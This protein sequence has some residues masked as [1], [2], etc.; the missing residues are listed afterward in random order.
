MLDEVTER[1]GE[2]GYLI[3]PLDPPLGRGISL[4][5]MVSDVDRLCQVIMVEGG[6][7]TRDIHDAWYRAGSC[8]IGQ[9]QFIVA[10]PDGYLLRFS[11]PLGTRTILL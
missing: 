11:Q 9:R 4:Q 3:G 6:R 1:T 7:I 5:I 2:T 8:E 10:D